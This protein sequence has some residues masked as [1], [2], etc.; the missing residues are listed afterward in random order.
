MSMAITRPR[1]AAGRCAAGHERHHHP[2]ADPDPV[3]GHVGADLDHLAHEL[4]AEYV[5]VL[6]GGPG[7]DVGPH[8][9]TPARTARTGPVPRHSSAAPVAAGTPA[10]RACR[11]E[12][13]PT[14]PPHR[15]EHLL[16]PARIVVQR[17]W[18]Y[19]LLDDHRR[20]GRRRKGAG[21]SCTHVPHSFRDWGEGPRVKPVRS[22]R[23]ISAKA[24]TASPPSASRL[25][26]GGRLT[27]YHAA[28]PWAR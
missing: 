17:W 11:P 1:R 10:G 23:R 26:H 24:W 20:A 3:R 14:A 15:S 19:L 25:P 4:V 13:R 2:V 28:E 18:A 6:H 5:A 22:A 8:A 12:R 27:V 7:P 21:G 9:L 16:E